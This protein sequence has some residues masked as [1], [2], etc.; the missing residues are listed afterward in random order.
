MVIRDHKGNIITLEASLC[1]CLSAHGAEVSAILKATVTS[2]QKKWNNFE[3]NCDDQRAVKEIVDF[4]NS[5]MTL[6]QFETSLKTP[7]GS[8]HGGQDNPTD[9]QMQ[10]Q[11]LPWL[12]AFL[13]FLF[14]F[15]TVVI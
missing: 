8:S 2:K 3:W 1:D 10:W 15:L 4:K 9:W 11:R 6:L 13:L 5:G 14:L 7:V 12:G